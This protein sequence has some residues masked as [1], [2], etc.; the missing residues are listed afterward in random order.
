[1]AAFDR[2]QTSEQYYVVFDFDS[3]LN[4]TDSDGTS[5]ATESISS[6]STIS[7]IDQYDDS[8][9]TSS[10]TDSGRHTYTSTK[11]YLWVK[12]GVSGHNYKITCKIIGSSGSHYEAD[13]ILPVLDK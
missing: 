5:L 12:G 9:V 3:D 7:V 2:K 11:A 8:V 6:L 13:G 4:P 1:M 10:L